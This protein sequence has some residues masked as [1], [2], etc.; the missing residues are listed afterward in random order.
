MTLG[1]FKSHF[2]A[3]RMFDKPKN[4]TEEVKEFYRRLLYH[5]GIWEK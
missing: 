5:G 3:S 1:S 2:G 4:S